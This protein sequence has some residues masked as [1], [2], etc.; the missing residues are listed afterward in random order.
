V[1]N[2]CGKKRFTGVWIGGITEVV[3]KRTG[4]TIDRSQGYVATAVVVVVGGG[5]GDADVYGAVRQYAGDGHSAAA[6]VVAVRAA[7][8]RR[9]GVGRMLFKPERALLEDEDGHDGGDHRGSGGVHERQ[10]HE[11]GHVQ[12]P[13]APHVRLVQRRRLRVRPVHGQ[14]PIVAEC[15][16]TGQERREHDG[17][18]ARAHRRHHIL[19]GAYVRAP[20]LVVP[21]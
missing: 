9:H 4:Y 19:A 2:T 21:Q 13:V 12:R 16:P 6:M 3:I 10:V 8:A 17:R 20:A 7:T 1:G 14:Y 11:A 15:E 18:D 5:S